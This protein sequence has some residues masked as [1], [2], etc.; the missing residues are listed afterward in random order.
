MTAKQSTD[1]IVDTPN[2]TVDRTARPDLPDY[3]D[4]P[5]S[6]ALV[7]WYYDTIPTNTRDPQMATES[8]LDRIAHTDA[9]KVLEI[10]E[11]LDSAR[12]WIGRPIQIYR[13]LSVE[14][15]DYD[16]SLIFVRLGV[17]DLDT[18]EQQ[19]INVGSPTIL[20]QLRVLYESGSLPLDCK[21]VPVKKSNKYNNPPLYL[22][23]LG[24]R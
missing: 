15:S 22:R 12:E 14:P 4:R 13:I 18:G 11:S 7:Q 3:A 5:V 20:Q 19:I 2:N 23:P 6:A 8:I 24:W 16:E 21:I 9:S 1:V 17:T 10:S